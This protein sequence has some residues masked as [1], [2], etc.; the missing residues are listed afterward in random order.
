MQR[1]S[2]DAI[3]ATRYYMFVSREGQKVRSK[4]R[5]LFRGLL[6]R[7]QADRRWRL[8]YPAPTVDPR[9]TKGARGDSSALANAPL[10]ARN[11]IE[12]STAVRSNYSSDT[13]TCLK[14][15]G[16]HRC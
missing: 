12:G 6:D 3:I 11:S 4:C 14:T 1:R 13:A 5:W 10:A 16:R 2:V 8:H 15:L 7:W 9:V